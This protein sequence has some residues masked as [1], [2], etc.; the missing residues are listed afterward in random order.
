MLRYSGVRRPHGER[1]RAAYS[2]CRTVWATS[3]VSQ[4]HAA[5]LTTEMLK[6]YLIIVNFLGAHA[7]TAID[8]MCTVARY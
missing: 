7:R 4:P 6:E 8:R 3:T 5:T 1:G 2:E